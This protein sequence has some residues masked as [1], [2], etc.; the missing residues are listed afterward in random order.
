MATSN[1]DNLQTKLE[2][3]PLTFTVH[4]PG[5]KKT[6]QYSYSITNR[7]ILNDFCTTFG[8][9]QRRAELFKLYKGIAANVHHYSELSDGDTLILVVRGTTVEGEN[10][11]YENQKDSLMNNKYLD[12]PISKD[13]ATKLLA[14]IDTNFCL[15]GHRNWFPGGSGYNHREYY[16]KLLVNYPEENES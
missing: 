14:E 10:E 8:I 1:V 11:Y 13:Q 9:V 3:N 7:S 4:L 15:F 5:Y 16:K 2:P 12:P 6:V